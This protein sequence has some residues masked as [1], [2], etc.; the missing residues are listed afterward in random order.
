MWHLPLENK[1]KYLIAKQNRLMILVSWSQHAQ[2]EFTA[3]RT[4][5]HFIA[6]NNLNSRSNLYCAASAEHD[7]YNNDRFWFPFVWIQFSD[8]DNVLN[9][10]EIAHR[11][12]IEV[13]LDKLRRFWIVY[14][15][16]GFVG[17]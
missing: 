13:L 2:V 9:V 10:E 12:E 16:S 14:F 7:R 4:V 11:K 1:G 8:Q 17:K 15:N 3:V 5:F 6:R